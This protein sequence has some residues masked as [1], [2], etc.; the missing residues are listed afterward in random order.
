MKDPTTPAVPVYGLIL[1]GGKGSRLGA[2]KGLLDYH[3]QSQARWLFEL[4]GTVCPERFL[5]IRTEQI[6]TAPY[7]DLPTILDSTAHEGPA[8]GLLAASRS[9]PGVAWLLVAVDMPLLRPVTLAALMRERDVSSWATAYCHPDGVVEP[10]CAIWEPPALAA[11]AAG[12]ANGG[13][14]GVS[15]RRL[16][17]RG[18]AKLLN[19]DDDLPLRSVNTAAD[20]AFVR[21][22]MGAC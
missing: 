2:D 7:A 8:S 13:P 18:P 17:E 4:V 1:A 10:L 14:R 12:A 15:L 16:L 11:V 6:G 19:I 20:D 21:R 9:F 3:G 5:S 22:V